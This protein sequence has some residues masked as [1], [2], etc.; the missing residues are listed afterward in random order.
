[1]FWL[2]A[3]YR[4]NMA[5]VFYD[6]AFLTLQTNSSLYIM[7]CFTPAPSQENCWHSEN[8]ASSCREM[9][10]KVLATLGRWPTELLVTH[11][12]FLPANGQFFFFFF[13]FEGLY[14]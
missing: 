5:H 14:F 11:D 12:W 4:Y 2:N 6:F 3:T 7:L 9:I 13:F 10:H 1:M 8:K